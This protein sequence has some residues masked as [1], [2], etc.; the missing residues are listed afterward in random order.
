MLCSVIIPARNAAST[1][2]E[3]L[4][5]TLSQSLPKEHYEI[6]VVDDGSSD[7]TARIAR[8]AG[9]RVIPQPPRGAA[10]A[11]NAG[12]RSARGDVLVFLDTDCV[13]KLDWLAQMI[14]PLDDPAVAGVRGAYQSH[15]AGLF[16]RL[17]QAEWDETYRQLGR[18][19]SIGAVSRNSAAYRRG[20][21]LAAGGFDPTFSGAED[22]DLSYRLTEAGHRLVFAPKAQVLHRHGHSV[23]G[24]IAQR[25]RAG[26]WQALLSARYPSE[27]RAEAQASGTARAQ[28]PLAA[29][30]VAS[31][32]AGARWRRAL[33]FAGLALLGFASSAGPSAWR[34]RHAGA[35]VVLA[36]P[37]LRFVGTLSLAIG[38]AAGGSVLVGH[39]AAQRLRRLGR[40]FDR[41][42]DRG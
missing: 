14:A 5:A 29:V 9:V 1:I 17:I 24:F 18:R 36:A 26:L 27:A 28:L 3:C 19:P 31:L 39:R 40:S 7:A 34:A 37:G 8:Q 16:P 4:L 42:S 23:A 20:A 15:E 13:P 10:A 32:L 6:I 25:V 21:F 22:L 35:D 41:A 2:G 12:A 38:L 33:P 30:A 11:R